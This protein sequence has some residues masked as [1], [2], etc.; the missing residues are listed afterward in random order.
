MPDLWI[1]TAE[2]L[3]NLL[4]AMI[5]GYS[6]NKKNLFNT[7]VE[8]I[9][10]QIVKIH[11]DY[12]AGFGEIRQRLKDGSKPP[13]ELI[14]FLRQ[15]RSDYEIERQLVRQ[16]AGQL[17]DAHRRAISGRDWKRVETY[18]QSIVQYFSA[19]SS[20]GC[21]GGYSWFT[22]FLETVEFKAKLSGG[23]PWQD[24]SISGNPA[25]DLLKGV[26]CALYEELP[27]AFERICRSY[28]ELRAEL[29]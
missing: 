3:W 18:C 7:H 5:S 19:S 12:L 10:A 15:R 27:A 25:D 8:P 1:S 13:L 9:Q 11:K 2:L 29:L 24:M 16:L 20:I 17:K 14:E 21:V 26:E 4:K 6:E 23:N 22:G 28:G